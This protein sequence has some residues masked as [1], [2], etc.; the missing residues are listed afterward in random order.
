M[1]LTKRE[2]DIAADIVSHLNVALDRIPY[3]EDFEHAHREFCLRLGNDMP[4]SHT[5]H[6]LLS[7]RKRG[8]CPRRHRRKC[9]NL[10]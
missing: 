6:V 9:D 1:E 4:P 7:A 2:L 5:W 10:N 8:M 3:T